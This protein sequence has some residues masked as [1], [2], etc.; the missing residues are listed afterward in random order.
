MSRIASRDIRSRV[1]AIDDNE[2]N[3][4]RIK[5]ARKLAAVARNARGSPQHGSCDSQHGRM[6]GWNSCEILLLQQRNASERNYRTDIRIFFQ[7]FDEVGC[8]EADFA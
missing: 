3:D 6:F 1:R 7:H 5:K 8:F 4:F 2:L